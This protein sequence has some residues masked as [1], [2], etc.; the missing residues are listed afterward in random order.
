MGGED[1]MRG[2]ISRIVMGGDIGEVKGG[3]VSTRVE[4][5][6]DA[7]KDKFCGSVAAPAVMPTI[8]NS[9]VVAVDTKMVWGVGGVGLQEGVDNELKPNSLGPPNVSGT[10]KSLPTWP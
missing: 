9:T 3:V 4:E 8:D 6:L 5:R 7:P 1:P 10:I 2:H